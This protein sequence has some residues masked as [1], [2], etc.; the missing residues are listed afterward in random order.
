M[1]NRSKGRNR[2]LRKFRLNCEEEL[3][4]YF[5]I[6]QLF[7]RGKLVLGMRQ[8]QFKHQTLSKD[9]YSKLTQK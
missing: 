3:A 5:I 8:S 7:E 4:Y 6:L 2:L 9:D 1:N